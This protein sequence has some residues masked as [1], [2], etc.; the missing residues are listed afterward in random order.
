LPPDQ[1]AP[2]WLAVRERVATAYHEAGHAVIAAA[3]GYEPEEGSTG[4]KRAI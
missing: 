3:L 1:A 2:L 4:K